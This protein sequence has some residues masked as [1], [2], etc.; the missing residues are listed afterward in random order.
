M[1][2]VKLENISIV[3]IILNLWKL[4][5]KRRRLQIMFLFC[6]MFLSSLT[7][8]FSLISVIPFLQVLVNP[9]SIFKFKIL[10]DITQFFGVNN[11]D[12]FLLIVTIIFVFSTI[13]ASLIRLLNLWFNNILAANIGS[14]LSLQGL[15]C[16][17][18]ITCKRRDI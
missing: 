7:E 14:D 4:I 13:V 10:V 16:S 6:L 18:Q 5:S 3:Y 12:N 11:S 1:S 17:S 9:D 8:I 15:A 2:N